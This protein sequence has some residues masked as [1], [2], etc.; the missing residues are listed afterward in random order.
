MRGKRSKQYRK[1]MQQYSLHFGFREPYQVLLD[2]AIL[3]D[4]ARFKMDFVSGLS[5]ALHG[6]IKP[7]KRGCRSLTFPA[8]RYQC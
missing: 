8:N 3:E 1:L 7:S 2:G 4:A 5:K 6:Q